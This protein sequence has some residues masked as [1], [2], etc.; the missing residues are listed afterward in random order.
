MTPAQA[1]EYGERF[2]KMI[3]SYGAI[4][5]DPLVSEYLDHL[6]YSLVAHSNQP[7][8]EF[9]FFVVNH[10]SV[11][12]FATF[13]GYVGVHT[14]LILAAEEESELAAVL[15]HE[16]AHVTQGHLFRAIESTQ[17]FALPTMLAA[18]AAALA[19]DS[20]E[21]G[22]GALAMGTAAVQ[23]AQIN[24]TR[25][26]EYEA[27]RLGVLMLHRAGFDPMAAVSFFE[28]MAQLG[29]RY[30]ADRRDNEVMRTHPVTSNRIAEARA[31]AT[32]LEPLSPPDPMPFYLVRSRVLAL[33]T[34]T[35]QA[36][37]L[38]V[39]DEI[40]RISHRPKQQSLRYA[41]ALLQLRLDNGAEAEAILKQLIDEQ[42][43]RAYRLALITALSRQNKHLTAV[44]LA[45]DVREQHPGNYAA[46]WTYSRALMEAGRA[47]DA[48]QVLDELRWQHQDA[49]R[50]F[51]ALAQAAD[52]ANRPLAAR[53]AM[54]RY[55]HLTGNLRLALDQY[56][57]ILSR[58]DADYYTRARV[59]SQL[60]Q[61]RE[62]YRELPASQRREPTG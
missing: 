21:G 34:R 19:A 54:A 24:F 32:N 51:E 49:P 43:L 11:N 57:G 6:A 52:R 31:R 41:E 47:E 14:G 17:K 37:L 45:E 8:A 48:Y 39:R 62:E 1:R 50:I 60:E 23:Q 28:K 3:R 53:E 9:S 16:I 42:P 18:I 25:A 12:A 29:R 35:P 5:E 38:R 59:Q 33:T 10:H 13:G 46:E 56:R 15:A 61:V 2:H 36:S 55:H 22:M 30:V 27:D 20:A 7:E 4:L 40:T 26:N 58:A 44:R